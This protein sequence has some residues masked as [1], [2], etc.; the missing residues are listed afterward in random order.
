M[1]SQ[2]KHA[3]NVNYKSNA[4]KLLYEVECEIL[5]AYGHTPLMQFCKHNK[6]LLDQDLWF[7][8]DMLKL[9]GLRDDNKKSALDYY[10]DGNQDLGTI[11]YNKLVLAERQWNDRA[12]PL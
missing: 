5:D 12:K 1:L 6:Q 7:I 4:F 9:V 11:G 3:K 10:V 8:E 2:S